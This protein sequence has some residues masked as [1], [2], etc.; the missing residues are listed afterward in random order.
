VADGNLRG[1]MQPK[2]RKL[3]VDFIEKGLG[4]SFEQYYE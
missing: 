3:L 1:K 2:Q 4:F